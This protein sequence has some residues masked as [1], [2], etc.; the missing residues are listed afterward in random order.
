MT[1][2]QPTTR[3]KH[4]KFT[5]PSAFQLPELDPQIQQV[6]ND[7]PQ[8]PRLLVSGHPGSGLSTLCLAALGQLEPST[9]DTGSTEKRAPVLICNSAAANQLNAALYDLLHPQM[10]SARPART[11]AALAFE[12]IKIFYIERLDPLGTPTILSGAELDALLGELLLS[13]ELEWEEKYGEEIR[14]SEFF[15]NET[16]AAVERALELGLTPTRIQKLAQGGPVGDATMPRELWE[17]LAR[18]LGKI[19]VSQAEIQRLTA[20]RKDSGEDPGQSSPADTASLS[21]N[22]TQSPLDLFS[23]LTQAADTPGA[24][25]ED[26]LLPELNNRREGLKLTAPGALNLATYLLQHWDELQ[27]L[28]GLNRPR[29]QW[30]AIVIDDLEDLSPAALN[31][32]TEASRTQPLLATYAPA[33]TISNYRGAKTIQVSELTQRL[34]TENRTIMGSR[35]QGADATEIVNESIQALPGFANRLGPLAAAENPTPVSVKIFDHHLTHAA[36]IASSIQE[37]HLKDGIPLNQIAILTRDNKDRQALTLACRQQGINVA[38]PGNQISLNENP[39]THTLLRLL[40]GQ[41]SIEEVF[42]SPLVGADPLA[43]AWLEREIATQN[44]LAELYDPDYTPSE[45]LKALSRDL[46]TLENLHQE[47]L[48]KQQ[49]PLFK[50]LLVT[51]QLLKT[52]RDVGGQSPA[53]ALGNI[54]ESAQKYNPEITQWQ[55]AAID[56]QLWADEY[57]DAAVALFRR[58]DLWEQLHPA[59]NARE[60]ATEEL[61]TSVAV[62]NLANTSIRPD[63]L[64]I[65]TI[66]SSAGKHFD[67]VY[68][69]PLQDGNFPNLRIRDSLYQIGNLALLSELAPGERLANLAGTKDTRAD[70]MRE[71]LQLFIHALTRAHHQVILT[72]IDDETQS[73]SLFLGA[74]PSI[75]KR[76]NLKENGDYQYQD[77]QERLNLRHLLGRLRGILQTTPEGSQ[78]SALELAARALVAKAHQKGVPG[79]DPRAWVEVLPNSGNA[80]LYAPEEQVALGPS[81]VKSILECP[82]RATLDKQVT[83][84]HTF[85]QDNGTFI[86]ELAE[87]YGQKLLAKEVQLG[88]LQAHLEAEVEAAWPRL[89]PQ[90][91]PLEKDQYLAKALHQVGLLAAYLNGRQEFP[92]KFE[93]K[94]DVPGPHFKIVGS[95]DRLE[96]D[97]QTGT[98]RVIDFKTG[99]KPGKAECE[100]NLQLACYQWALAESGRTPNGAAL[101]FLNENYK[102]PN[103][104]EQHP[105]RPT[106]PGDLEGARL[107]LD[108]LTWTGPADPEAGYTHLEVTELISAAAN[109]VRGS[110]L[111]AIENPNCA[112]CSYR[113]VCP[114]KESGRRT[115]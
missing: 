102:K 11:P 23:E 107:D 7:W 111:A 51:A 57:L 112:F 106:P 81:R 19:D 113:Q 100:N 104:L 62:A 82:L 93:E 98:F 89:H 1:S 17:N 5:S 108:A 90:L 65:M 41:A 58:A 21:E 66:A 31:F 2:Q 38:E 78:A 114:Q 29:P 50:P 3:S 16:R 25:P 86:H 32:L 39:V 33:G 43:Y 59:Q 96:S 70:K 28:E 77:A 10:L 36:W 37:R 97:P 79:A 34:Q 18:I 56:G 35:F 99:K 75:V 15:R 85:K 83:K 87:K 71:E 42:Y 40:A 64:N 69:S 95:I 109:S 53:E 63:A 20:A 115:V 91:S 45:I 67:T 52:A 61:T 92:A 76:T 105:L 84:P 24:H 49:N 80:P 12:V 27:N 74:L 110:Q 22:F 60:Y 68:L 55:Q 73:P 103:S 13:P 47:Y 54:W 44:K 26:T 4:L 94:L 8:H 9:K 48:N 72:A 30:E 88:D 46:P 101:V 6:L 14:A